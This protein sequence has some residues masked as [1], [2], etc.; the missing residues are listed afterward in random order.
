VNGGNGGRTAAFVD[1]ERFRNDLR[2]GGVEEMF[3]MLL[4][5]FSLDC[6]ARF[7]ALES[8]IES[9]DP[10]A[11]KSAAH[12]F[13]SGAITIR[14]EMLAG[15]LNRMEE[16]ARSGRLESLADLFE[17]IRAQKT[18]VLNTLAGMARK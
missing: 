4:D 12:A 17:E 3:G 9:R 18:G 16:A 7:A 11:I 5:T 15:A 10:G 6:P 14:A 13:K 2:E 1:L 8:A